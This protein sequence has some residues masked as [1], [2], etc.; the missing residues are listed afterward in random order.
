MRRPALLVL[1]FALAAGAPTGALARQGTPG[2]A[3]ATPAA[4]AT[5]E[6]LAEAELAPDQLPAEVGAVLMGYETVEPWRA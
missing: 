5:S 4:G 6:V 2:P 3:A 1:V